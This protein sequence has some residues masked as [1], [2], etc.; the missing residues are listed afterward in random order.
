MTAEG[1]SAALVR[2]GGTLGIVTDRDLRSRVVAAG[3]S[4]DAPVSAIMTTPV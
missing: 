2:S 1:A 4:P 3:A